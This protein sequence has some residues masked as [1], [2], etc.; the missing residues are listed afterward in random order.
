MR[1][2]VEYTALAEDALKR[3]ETSHGVVYWQR[4]AHTW[5]TLALVAAQA[6]FITESDRMRV[7]TDD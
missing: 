5:A 3:A 7:P 1:T 2:A 6:G 4:R